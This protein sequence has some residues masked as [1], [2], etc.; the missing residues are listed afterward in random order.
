MLYLYS[1]DGK[2]Q[3][4]EIHKFTY[5]GTFLGECFVSA[6]I[7]TEYPIHFEIGDYFEFRGERFTL[8]YIPAKQKQARKGSYGSAFVYDNIKF[9]SLADELTRVEFLDVVLQ[10]NGIHYTSLPDFSF[11]A[12][13]V[14]DLAD[15][16]QAN[17]NRVYSGAQQWTV[18]VSNDIITKDKVVNVSKINCLDAVALASS[19]F[20]VNFIV[21]NRT[22]TIG[23]AGMAVGKVFG[24]GKGK[25]LYDIQQTTNEDALI[26]TRLRAYGNTRNIP[27][28][29]YNKLKKAN[30]Q[31]FISDGVYIPNLMLPS[32]PY[33]L[34]DPAKVFIDSPKMAEYGLRE[35]SVYFDGSDDLPD[36]FPSLEGM[37]KLQLNAAGISVSLQNGDNGNIDECLSADNPTD[38]GEIPEKGSGEIPAE[39]TICLKDLGF[40]L[41]EKDS[42][43]QYK[44]A[45]GDTMQISMTSGMCAGRTFDVMDNGIVKDTVLGY[46]RYKI[47][48]KRFTDDTIAGGRAFPNSLYK[49]NAGDKFVI[50]G[51]EMPDVYVKAAA[52]RLQVA[53]N[54]YLGLHDQTK[55]TYTPKIDEIFMANNPA[56][57]EN[58]KEGDILNFDDTDLEIDASVIIQTLKIEVGA[59]LVPTYEVTLGNERVTGTIEKMQNAISQLASNNTGITVDQVKSVILS[60]GAKYFLSRL[61]DD[62]AEG[63]ITFIKNVSVEKELTVHETL[64][65]KK[66]VVSNQFGNATFTSG[67]FGS[68]FRVWQNP[69]NGQSYAELDN[70][71]IRRDTVFN[72]LTIAD[73]KSVGGQI[74][75]SAA[76]MVCLKVETQS[77]G[78]KCYFDTDAEKIANRFAVND[79]AICRRFNGQGVKY[80]WRRVLSAGND[81]IVLSKTDADGTGI[82]EKG[83][84]IIQFGNRTDTNRQSAILISAYG[85]DSPSIKQYAGINSYNLTGKEVTAITPSGNKFTGTFEVKSGNQLVRVP[86]DRGTWTNG[87][88]CYYYDRVSYNGAL[89]LCIIPEGQTT[90]EIPSANSPYWQKQ[91]AEG[92]QGDKGDRGEAGTL[93]YIEWKDKWVPGNSTITGWTNSGTADENSRVMG[94][95]PFGLQSMLWKCVPN[96]DG[97]TSGGFET[98][99]V[100]LDANYAYRYTLFVYINKAGGTTYHGCRNVANLSDNAINGNPYFWNGTTLP[101]GKWCLMVGIIHPNVI[102]TQSGISGV[103]DMDG[104]KLFNGTDYK[105]ATD[106]RAVS[107]RSYL[108]YTADSTINQLFFNPMVHKLDGTEPSLDDILQTRSATITDA[109]FKVLD[110]AIKTKVSQTDF[111]TLQGRVAT[112]ESTVTQHAAKIESTI[113]KVDGKNAVYKSLT[114]ATADRPVIPYSKN[115][116]WITYTGEIKQSTVTRLTGSFVDA[117]WIATTK[118]TDDTA[119][120]NAHDTAV[121]KIRYIRDWLNGSTA[122]TG[123]HW[124][125]IMAYDTTGTNIALNKSVS[126]DTTNTRITNGSTDTSVYV[127]AAEGLKHVIVDLGAACEITKVKVWHYNADGRTYYKTKT[128]ASVDK[129]NWFPLFDST[130]EGTYKETAAGRTYYVRDYDNTANAGLRNRTYYSDTTPTVPEAGHKE[131]DLWYKISLTNGCYTTYRWNGSAWVIIN[132]YVSKAQ[133]TITDTSITNL[134]TKTGINSL[135]VGETLLSKI[136][137]TADNI[138][139]EVA[140]VQIGGRNL[141]LNSNFANSFTSWGTNG[142]TRTIETDAI[143]GTVA[144]IVATAT[145]HGIYQNPSPRRTPGKTYV[146][147]GYMKAATNMNVTFSHEGGTGSKAF[148][149]TTAWQR[150]ETQGT[151]TSGGS[152]C[153]Y[154]GGAGTFYLANLQYEEGNKVTAWSQASEDI[155]QIVGSTLTLT[156]NKITLASKTIELNG[157]TIAKAIQ[158]EDLKVG[159]RAGLSALEVTKSG[160]LYAKGSN[161]DAS[162]SLTIDSENQSLEIVSPKTELGLGGITYG[163]TKISMSGRTGSI[164]I[165]NNNGFS[166]LGAEGIFSNRAGQGFHPAGTSMSNAKAAVSGLGFASGAAD[167]TFP[168]YNAVIGVAGRASNSLGI[169]AAPAYGGYFENLKATGFI[170]NTKEVQ[171]GSTYLTWADSL[172]VGYGSGNVYLPTDYTIGRVV[173][174]RAWMGTLYVYPPSGF[175]LYDDSTA[176]TSIEVPEGTTAFCCFIRPTLSG[177]IRNVWLI[178][179]WKGW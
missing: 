60:Y 115:D 122:N 43:K 4:A 27:N 177:V 116:L 19:E 130:I 76:S 159:S 51:I 85:S 37:T 38:S 70:L 8:N 93:N 101:V 86:A 132:E 2:I 9:N 162:S 127:S 10:D 36:I 141:L 72:R 137:Q 23:T 25:G 56:I 22:I 144:K 170:L 155:P 61:S 128:E 24:Y 167:T 129:V 6:K 29:Y 88:V 112:A 105:F 99:T 3:K 100:K 64:T 14:K 94:T 118:Y 17:L 74:L 95:N 158:A 173:L 142:G 54:D 161:Q 21:R 65:A 57:G 120:T 46:T 81:Y 62:T 15:R 77:D 149:V 104:R 114:P 163:T 49:V 121:K 139:L 172:V 117:D 168:D 91:V 28:R 178:N 176:N 108:Y 58:I 109:S 133:Q 152:V 145:N 79:Q 143:F 164:E 71:M 97:Y 119:A 125:Q 166:K 16:I 153:F 13:N 96:A 134:V 34:S 32:F 151:W 26:I 147:S 171:G 40:D 48:C 87:M 98:A 138:T 39:F 123:N 135:G 103:Y 66:D 11:Y 160:V 68:G 92:K 106:D 75:V 1:K 67:Q 150:F 12:N 30:G 148:A 55:Y 52:Q 83:D 107:F 179:K 69:D 154:S 63:N 31:P 7:E 140:K 33:T 18:I 111:T 110:D 80:Y 102:T 59:K 42:K 136:N 45:T 47:T 73:I 78:Y 53:A 124:V 5:Q 146:I 20:G 175:L 126:G 44:Y 157:T 82:P 169:T 156:D 41:S 90:T 174:V 89:W 50:L 165:R 84:D 113:T 131:G 35:G